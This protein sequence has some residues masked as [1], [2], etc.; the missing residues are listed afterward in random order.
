MLQRRKTVL[1]NK[2]RNPHRSSANEGQYP[3]IRI[4]ATRGKPSKSGVLETVLR[5]AEVMA[6]F[7]SVGKP[8]ESR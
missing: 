3:S 5:L 6:I 4:D 8:A 2:Y 7:A 1:A